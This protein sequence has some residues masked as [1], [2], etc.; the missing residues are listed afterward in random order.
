MQRLSFV[1]PAVSKSLMLR[2]R[3]VF[4][5]S[6]ATVH[7]FDLYD[8]VY[9]AASSESPPPREWRSEMAQALVSSIRSLPRAI[10]DV[11]KKALFQEARRA[12][13]RVSP[14]LKR[15]E[16]NPKDL[17]AY[18]RFSNEMWPF[19]ASLLRAAKIEPFSMALPGKVRF[20]GIGLAGSVAE[21]ELPPVPTE[22]AEVFT[23][24]E[25][26]M[27]TRA[28]QGTSNL[29]DLYVQADEAFEQQ[30]DLL[31]RGRG[32][33]R[34]LGAGVFMPGTGAKPDY[35]IPGPS[36][37]IGPIKKRTRVIEKALADDMDISEVLDIVRATV[38]V[39]RASD[40]PKVMRYLREAGIQIARRPKN[41][42]T[43]PTSVGYRDLMFNI[44]YPNG[45]I[46]ELQ[47]NLKPMLNAKGIG[48]KFYETVRE[49]EARMKAQNRVTMTPEEQQEVI[50]ANRIQKDLYDEAWRQSS[51]SLLTRAAY[52]AIHKTSRSRPME[53][54][55]FNDLPAFV[56]T[57]ARKLPVKTLASGRE[58]P[59][60]D[61]QTFY[62]EAVPLTR[63]E[64]LR[65]LQNKGGQAF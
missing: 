55:D 18:T 32:L 40:I 58:V 25:A 59:V 13:S 53:Y 38:A 1:R 4:R 20:L 43:T 50:D 49:I 37:V 9:Q 8:Q 42:F 5:L 29:N 15:M 64:Y 36:V 19:L 10:P 14:A 12:M 57:K 47:I 3:R 48:H 2:L 62:R 21:G 31:N 52:L 24:E 46:G 34:A 28:S 22:I 17:L 63:E 54:F 44:R 30:L 16:S 6:P 7:L 27:P 23:V 60:L 41:R 26:A 56:D 45:H 33:D 11:D 51:E 61:L 39:D 35:T 65:L